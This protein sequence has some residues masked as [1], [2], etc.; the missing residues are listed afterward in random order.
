MTKIVYE[1][2][3]TAHWKTLFHNKTLLLGSHNLNEGEELVA[4]IS[5]VSL[6]V[7][8]N[9][10][11]KDEEVAVI[12]FTNAPPMV[13]NITNAKIISSL[14]GD[15]YTGWIGKSIQLYAT[16]VKAFGNVTMALRVKGAIPNTQQDISGYVT[17]LEICQSIEALQQAFINMPTHIK[18]L[19]N[20][21]KE[22]M[23]VK[24]N[25]NN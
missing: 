22:K 2:S 1:P 6:Q 19:V 13:M 24:L 18:P 16:Q 21:V 4:E 20:D 12:N 25:A 14:Y 23:K 3:E 11:G 9:M 7:I 8:K 5:E 15:L 17:Q 10:S